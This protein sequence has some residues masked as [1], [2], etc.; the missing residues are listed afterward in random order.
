MAETKTLDDFLQ[1]CVWDLAAG[2][3][4]L[5]RRTPAVADKADEP[6]LRHSLG[7]LRSE[8]E[9]C[10]DRL[11]A[12]TGE[13]SGP[14]NLWMAGILDDAERDT[15]TLPVGPLLDLAIVG[16]IRKALQA[17]RA[18]L[19]TAQV[20]ARQLADSAA[21]ATLMSCREATEARDRALFDLLG[22]LARTAGGAAG[23]GGA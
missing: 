18:S 16:A 10:A 8:A 1:L 13:R 6:A 7:Q 4:L 9:T 21:I 19:D 15:R 20:V 14:E 11:F 3:R 23:P 17:Q 2:A 22:P 12:T 5:A